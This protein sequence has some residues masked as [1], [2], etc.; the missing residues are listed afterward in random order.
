M[1]TSHTVPI[2]YHPL[3]G[4]TISHSAAVLDAQWS[5]KI[6]PRPPW[7]TWGEGCGGGRRGRGTDGRTDVCFLLTDVLRCVPTGPLGSVYWPGTAH[8]HH[9]RPSLL[10]DKKTASAGKT[11]NFSPLWPQ[12]RLFFSSHF[13]LS[14][15]HAEGICTFVLLPY[16]LNK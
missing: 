7:G 11:T 16:V 1:C 4:H 10:F 6:A 2:V 13:N 15:T 3:G 9:R 5:S 8:L 14:L 12:H